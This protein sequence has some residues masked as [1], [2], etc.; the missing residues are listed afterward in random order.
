[1]KKDKQAIYNSLAVLRGHLEE[2]IKAGKANNLTKRDLELFSAIKFKLNR[3]L[4]K[5]GC[6]TEYTPA[7]N[8]HEDLTNEVFMEADKYVR[9]KRFKPAKIKELKINKEIAESVM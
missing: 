8:Y 5:L 1:M 7:D 6:Y 4:E 3:E 9:D 2:I